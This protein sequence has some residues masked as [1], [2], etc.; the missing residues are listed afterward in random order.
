MTAREKLGRSNTCTRVPTVPGAS[1][2]PAPQPA[3]QGGSTG[4]RWSGVATGTRPLPRCPGWPPCLRRGRPRP[5]SP[6]ADCPS[7]A[8]GWPSG[9]CWPAGTRAAFV[10]AFAAGPSVL[11]GSDEFEESRPACRRSASSSTRNASINI[12]CSATIA[13][14]SAYE[15]GSDTA[16]SQT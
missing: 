14:N 11:G 12:A 10:F 13:A 1:A 8:A 9:A 6:A 7:D 3:Q 15:G 2:R 4:S 16:G 5:G